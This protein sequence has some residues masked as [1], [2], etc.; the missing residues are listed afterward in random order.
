MSVTGSPKLATAPKPP[1]SVLT[2]ADVPTVIDVVV[3]RTTSCGLRPWGTVKVS[4]QGPPFPPVV[5]S[6]AAP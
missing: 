1:V 5:S 2:V 4:V 6:A 3:D